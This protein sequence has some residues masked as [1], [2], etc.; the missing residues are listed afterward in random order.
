MADYYKIY[1][2]ANDLNLQ[3][4]QTIESENEP[5]QFNESRIISFTATLQAPRRKLLSELVPEKRGS[6]MNPC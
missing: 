6:I 1:F 5:R 2:Y 3:L 4:F